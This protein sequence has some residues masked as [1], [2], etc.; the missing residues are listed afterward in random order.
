[1]K[2]YFR[3]RGDKWSFTVDIGIDPETGKRKQKSKS[4]F[5]T[6]KEAQKA[7]AALITQVE[8]GDYFEEKKVTVQEF[9]TLWLETVA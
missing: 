1:M 4:G 3:K 9:M 7:A 2:G 6:K 8:C 5:K